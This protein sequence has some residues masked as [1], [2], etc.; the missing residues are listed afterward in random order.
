MRHYIEQNTV[1]VSIL[2]FLLSYFIILLYQPS[3]LFNRD[4]S[5]RQF[6][7]NRSSTTIIP[8]WLVVIIVAILSYYSILY[9]L[10]YPKLIF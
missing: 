7:L 6:G 2:L 5:L 9:Y 1:Q 4:G 10:T 8:V 3:F